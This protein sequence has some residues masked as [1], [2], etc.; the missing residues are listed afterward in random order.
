MRWLILALAVAASPAAAGPLDERWWQ[1]DPA[2]WLVLPRALMADMP[3][4]WRE[5]MAE[6]LDEWDAA[7]GETLR[8]LDV[9]PNVTARDL[10]TGRYTSM[11]DVVFGDTPEE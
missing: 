9:R 7:H 1:D 5:R 11:P 3:L 8:G 10:R 2:M 6:L 4:D